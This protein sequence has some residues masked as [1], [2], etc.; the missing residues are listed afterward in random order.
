MEVTKPRGGMTR[1]TRVTIF[2]NVVLI[3]ALGVLLAL[4]T[5]W[6]VGRLSWKRDVRLDLT[7]DARFSVDPLG[8]AVVRGLREPVR[9]T[10]VF[11][12]DDEIR[13]RAVDVYGQP[14]ADVLER[15]YRPLLLKAVSRVQ[16]VMLEWTKMSEQFTF[17]G[18]D[19][20]VEPYRMNE[21]AL[22]SGKTVNDLVR[23]M[24]QVVF[25]MGT[26]KRSV[27]MGR[28][29]PIDW[30]YIAPDP[31]APSKPPEMIGTPHPQ[32]ELIEALRALA[33][34]EAVKVGMPRGTSA[35]VPTE[36]RDFDSFR[37]FLASQGFEA[38]PFDLAR[39]VPGDVGLVALLG[40][41]RRLLPEETAELDKYERAGGRLLLAADPRKPED[42]GRVLEPYGVKIEAGMVEDPLRMKPRQA[43]PSFL[44][45]DELY[46][47]LHEIDRPIV[48]GRIGLYVGVTRPL[49][50]ESLKS[51]GAERILLLR[52]SQ[53]AKVIPV[54]YRAGS[55]EPD[56]NTSAKKSVPNAPLAAA[57]RR[58]T[59]SGKESRVAVF[60][61]WEIASPRPIEQGTN[62]GNR[63]FVLNTLN[64][65]A[66][67]PV[68]GV[69]EREIT[70]S[71]V[72]LTPSFDGRF[73]WVML[74]LFPSLLVATG[75]VVFLMRRN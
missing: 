63:D 28:M 5:I 47:G 14:R 40:P 62:Y 15:L 48:V 17:E 9:A 61:G 27:P 49:V 29:F 67:R 7:K 4:A 30:G 13:K 33:A 34:G 18:V 23:G 41:G 22:R 39:G 32:S 44:L 60:G 69:V 70:S 38:A 35:G 11:G 1:S 58:P 51:E 50:I 26:R 42:F 2:V 72:E 37:D 10:L 36:G 16:K 57:L 8:E 65:L 21:V 64:W 68:V 53:D 74:G 3:C 43:D 59:P 12:I 31:R 75:V 55:G 45:S 6:L 66:D 73:R 46:V 71:K 54:E 52:A 19:A 20:D 24:N 25:E 56:F